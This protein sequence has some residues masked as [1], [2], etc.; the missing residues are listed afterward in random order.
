MTPWLFLLCLVH[1]LQVPISVESERIAIVGAGAGGT[2][3]AYYLQRY[4]HFGY[5]ITIFEKGDHIGG[6]TSTV[7]IYGDSLRPFEIGGSIFVSANK[8]LNTAADRFNLT[9]I[10]Y[11]GSLSLERRLER[12]GLYDGET[13]FFQFEDSWRSY[14]KILWRYGR[15]PL[16]VAR[17]TRNFV[18]D[19]LHYFYK[20]N[21]PFVTLDSVTRTSGIYSASSVFAQDYFS[22]AGVSESYYKEMVQALT[23]VNY[24]QNVDQIHALGALVSMAASEASQIKGGNWQIFASFA[25]HSKAKLNLNT[26]VSAIS[27]LPDGKWRLEYANSSAVFDK[28]IIAS[29]MVGNITLSSTYRVPDVEYVDLHVTV[30][31]SNQQI[32]PKYFGKD[33]SVPGTILTTVY[34]SQS[35]PL[36]FF[37]ISI[38]EY[39]EDTGD[40]VFKIFSPQ[41]FSEDDIASLFSASAKI[42]WVHRKQWRSYPYIRPVLR[43]ADFELDD[44]LW[45]LNSMETLMSTMETS[46]LAGANV[47]ALIS[48]GRNKTALVVP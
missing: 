15:S 13:I 14:L 36:K 12:V 6:R 10:K 3:A 34:L 43:F 25:K 47:A 16:T 21:F 2:A 8:I 48:E 29:P 45:Y 19:F 20:V 42:S 23:R 31:T 37:S 27:K 46:A 26:E 33:S 5:N 9:K 38:H 17:L 24:A 22:E 18:A 28:V 1:A 4:T 30:F 39:L 7:P 41:A 40:Y 11:R 44:G 35:P 32:N